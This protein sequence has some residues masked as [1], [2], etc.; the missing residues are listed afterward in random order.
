MGLIHA[1]SLQGA[2]DARLGGMTEPTAPDHLTYAEV[3]ALLRRPL[4]TLY[5]MVHRG[6]IPYVRIGP[7]TVLFRRAD[8][9]RLLAEGYHSGATN[10]E[11]REQACVPAGTCAPRACDD[12]GP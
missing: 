11:R 8:I 5:A 10:E 9:E 6:Q 2:I 7:R 4:A 3:A 1:G 12:S